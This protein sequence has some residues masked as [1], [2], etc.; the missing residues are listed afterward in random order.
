MITRALAA[1]CLLVLIGCASTPPAPVMARKH[2]VCQRCTCVREI[3]KPP[4]WAV[5]AKRNGCYISK[6]WQCTPCN[7]L[8]L[9]SLRFG[10]DNWEHHGQP[11]IYGGFQPYYYRGPRYLPGRGKIGQTG[12][13]GH[14]GKGKGHL[15][16]N[17]VSRSRGIQRKTTRIR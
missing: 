12:G 1:L 14:R 8:H 16:G 5:R 15:R 9:N 6:Y 10:Y 7:S 17:G 3:S 4:Y 11:I 2:A 13:E